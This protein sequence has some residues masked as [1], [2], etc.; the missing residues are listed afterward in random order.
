MLDRSAPRRARFGRGH[1]DGPWTLDDPDPII[2][3]NVDDSPIPRSAGVCTFAVAVD[4]AAHL[5]RRNIPDWLAGRSLASSGST[6]R[7]R[8]CS[9]ALPIDAP[10][11]SRANAT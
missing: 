11:D 4:A 9:S 5:L 10:H 6:S 7:L 8:A 3:G 2:E 1:G